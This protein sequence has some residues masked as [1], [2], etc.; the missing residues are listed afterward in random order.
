MQTVLDGLPDGIL[1]AD[2]ETRRFVFC[3]QAMRQMLGY[4]PDEIATL[5]LADLHPAEAM[6][7]VLT[8]FGRDTQQQHAY[9]PD[10]P[11]RRKDSS[12]FPAD[13]HTLQIDLDGR[14][15]VCGVF[16]DI[17]LRKQDQQRIV[18]AR[19]EASELLLLEAQ[20]VAHIGH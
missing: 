14:P 19:A 9:A 4:S 3:N 17:S 15:C 1:I 16:S 6:P 18:E 7:R 13:I 2:A 11:V 10:L 20:K 8:E 12:T 5:S